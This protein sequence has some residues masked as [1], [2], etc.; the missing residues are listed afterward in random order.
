VPTRG[1]LR[2][3]SI[4]STS[5][6]RPSTGREN[7]D[8][9]EHVIELVK[10]APDVVVA[11]CSQAGGPL[12]GSQVPMTESRDGIDEASVR[13]GQKGLRVLAFAARLIADDEL[14]TMTDDPMS[15]SGSRRR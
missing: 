9:V 6:W 11:R 1:C 5:S 15:Y 14:A 10:G 12:S 7:V 3:R 4:P 2:F 8:G 13:M